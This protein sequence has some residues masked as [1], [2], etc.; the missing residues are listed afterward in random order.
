MAG[1]KRKAAGD[2]SVRR[3]AGAN[4]RSSRSRADPAGSGVGKATSR[5]STAVI[6]QTV[7]AMSTPKQQP[8]WAYLRGYHNQTTFLA[9]LLNTLAETLPL[10]WRRAGR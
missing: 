6:K 3:P 1:T 10:K 9:G 8:L 7:S 5:P 4:S 2:V